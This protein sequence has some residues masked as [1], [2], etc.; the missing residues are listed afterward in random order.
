VSGDIRK[1]CGVESGLTTFDRLEEPQ[2]K[3][4]MRMAA[5]KA[6]AM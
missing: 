5:I 2:R 4:K 3:R 6:I 1:K